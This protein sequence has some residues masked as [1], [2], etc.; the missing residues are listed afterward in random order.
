MQMVGHNDAGVQPSVGKMQGDLLTAT[1]CNISVSVEMHNAVHDLA[2]QWL[3]SPRSNSD[4]VRP[5]LRIVVAR[6]PQR[7]PSIPARLPLST[8]HVQPSL[9]HHTWLARPGGHAT[10]APLSPASPWPCQCTT[11]GLAGPLVAARHA[12]RLRGAQARALIEPRIRSTRSSMTFMLPS[13]NA[14][15]LIPSGYEWGMPG[16]IEPRICPRAPRSPSC[17]LP[18]RQAT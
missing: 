11:R 18:R 5:R 3:P 9:T 16:I 10:D 15:D 13:Q 8:R 6:Q 14:G 1:L 12:V 17:C 4:R 7:A 2:E